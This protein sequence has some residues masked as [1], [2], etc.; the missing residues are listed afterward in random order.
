MH[1]KR[2]KKMK[3]KEVIKSHCFTFVLAISLTFASIASAQET[4]EPTKLGKWSKPAATSITQVDNY[5][6]HCGEMYEQT[7]DIRKQYEAIDAV[8]LNVGEA[9]AIVEDDGETLK[10]KIEEYKMLLN[11]I[12]GQQADIEKLPVLVEA[13]A[14][15]IP[16]GLK[17]VAATKAIAST[18]EVIKL[19]IQENAS[20]IKV[21]GKQI[22]TLSAAPV[23]E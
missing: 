14:K 10:A 11:R 6:N 20:L 18:K 19:V 2:I 3:T 15:S 23:T 9:M 16:L 17:A 5:V 12:Q 1:L 4:L 21:I 7:M 22:G 13:A 8:T